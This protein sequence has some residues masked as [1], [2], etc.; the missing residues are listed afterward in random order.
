MTPDTGIPTIWKQCPRAPASLIDMAWVWGIPM[1]SHHAVTPVLAD[2]GEMV[3]ALALFA[4]RMELM[5][6]WQ[7]GAAT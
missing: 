2:R 5:A 4:D 7:R 3:A 6:H 1:C